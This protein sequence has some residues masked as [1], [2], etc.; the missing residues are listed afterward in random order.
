MEKASA[1]C[2]VRP[3]ACASAARIEPPC[4]TITTSLPGLGFGDPVQRR[5][6]AVLHLAEALAARRLL[7]GGMRPEGVRRVAQQLDQRLVRD[8]LPLAEICSA[9]SGSTV[10]GAVRVAGG[11]DGGGGGAGAGQV[12]DV[13][14]RRAGQARGQPA[15]QRRFLPQGEVA[16][17]DIHVAVEDGS[18]RGL[19]HARGGSGTGGWV[20]ARGRV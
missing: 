3:S 13:P 5:A 9:R 8:A 11:E 14:A 12:G 16:E 20:L 2:A 7:I 10:S 1:W 15:V 18:G 4:A 19:D 17:R 6:D